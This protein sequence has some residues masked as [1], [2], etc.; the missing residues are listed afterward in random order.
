MFPMEG[1]ARHNDEMLQGETADGLSSSPA[2]H[3]QVPSSPPSAPLID[4]QPRFSKT[5]AVANE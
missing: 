2:R 4:A 1:Q 3:G 5:S